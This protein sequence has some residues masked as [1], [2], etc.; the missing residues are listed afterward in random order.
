MQRE[1]EGCDERGL[2]I[3]E[4]AVEKGQHGTNTN[5]WQTVKHARGFTHCENIHLRLF[6]AGV[7]IVSRQHHFVL[8]ECVV[9][10]K[11]VVV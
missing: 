7:I 5:S 4:R 3:C 11:T 1:I 6:D 9:Q 8:E 10:I 2:G